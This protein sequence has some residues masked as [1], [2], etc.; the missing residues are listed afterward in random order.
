MTKKKPTRLIGLRAYLHFIRPHWAKLLFTLFLFTIASATLAAIPVVI[1]QLVQ[2][3]AHTPV[4]VNQGWL[5]AWVLVFLSAGH[6]ILWRASELTYRKLLTHINYDYENV[7]FGSVINKPYQFFVDKLTGKIGS[8]VVMITNEFRNLLAGIY[9]NFSG[10][11]VTIIA[12]FF[13][14]GTLNWQTGLIF[15]IGIVGMFVVGKYSL[16]YNMKMEAKAADVAS[17]KNG[18]LYDA[19]ANY[20]SVKAFHT[21]RQEYKTIEREQAKA[22]HANQKAFL[23]GIIFWTSMSLFVRHLIWPTIVLLN[24]WFFMHGQLSLGGLATLLSTVLMFSNTIWNGVWYVSQVGQQLAR[25]DEAHLYLFGETVQIRD[26]IGSQVAAPTFTKQLSIRNLNFAYPDKPDRPVLHD[27]SLDIKY[28]EKIGIVGHSGSGKTTLTKLLL[29]FYKAPQGVIHIDDKPATSEAFARLV[30]FVP[31]DTSLFHRSI[32]DNIGYGTDHA[33]TIEDV[34]RAAK[35]ACAD[36]FIDTLP[37]GYDTL[38]G[39]RGTKLSGGQRQ[40]IAIARAILQNRPILILDE[41][42]SALDSESEVKIQKAL[43][44]LWQGKTVIAVAHRLSTLRHMDR[45]IVMEHGSVVEDG[46]HAELLKRNGIYASLW[47]H[48]SGGFIE[49]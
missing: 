33:S 30:S 25:I 13:I 4:D 21:E 5:L 26:I 14:L 20:A 35:Q 17:D 2:T 1:G 12:I 47:H 3:L 10:Q 38:I 48:Q 45:I 36:E 37:D 41:A 8:Y 40:R 34:K 28:G 9:F 7:L 18:I 19:I 46:S 44:T 49:E 42:T 32:T 15:L 43:D 31:Q 6:D 29:D 24:V 27:I 39:E 11:L 22:F 16:A 23:S